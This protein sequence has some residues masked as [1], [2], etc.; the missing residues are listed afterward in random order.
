MPSEVKT[1]ICLESPL[2]FVVDFK[3]EQPVNNNAIPNI[4]KMYFIMV[5]FKGL[6]YYKYN[7]F[8]T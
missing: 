6:L 8:L 1:V 3:L 7:I 5:V 4:V 2:R